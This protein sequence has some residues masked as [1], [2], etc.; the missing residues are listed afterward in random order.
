MIIAT[1]GSAR[2]YLE[3]P[4]LRAPHA[5]L[6]FRSET[7]K[8]YKGALTCGPTRG[9]TGASEGATGELQGELQGKTLATPCPDQPDPSQGL[10]PSSGVWA[11]PGPWENAASHPRSLAKTLWS[12]G[13]LSPLSPFQS[14]RFLAFPAFFFLAFCST[15]QTFNARLGQTSLHNSDCISNS[16]LFTHARIQNTQSDKT[17]SSS[18]VELLDTGSLKLPS[19]DDDNKRRT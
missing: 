1:S 16:L 6:V 12:G 10:S 8:A 5:V 4:Q 13:G 7:T 14:L 2:P 9:L 18:F 11:H 15:H 3:H 19:V 17:V